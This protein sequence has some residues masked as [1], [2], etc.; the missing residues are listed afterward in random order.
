MYAGRFYGDLD[1]DLHCEQDVRMTLT[2]VAVVS[3]LA[4]DIMSL[5]RMQ[6]GHEIILS[7]GRVQRLGRAGIRRFRPRGGHQTAPSGGETT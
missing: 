7:R 4:F 6:E 2:N 5:N 3:G 1:L